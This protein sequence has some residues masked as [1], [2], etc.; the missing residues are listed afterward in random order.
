MAL[1]KISFSKPK[2]F[3]LNR[4][5]LALTVQCQKQGDAA[6]TATDNITVSCP[7]MSHGLIDDVSVSITAVTVI[8]SMCNA[9]YR[10]ESVT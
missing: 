9:N 1:S 5:Y 6:I 2:I 7:I 10:F 4:I 3:F 8:R